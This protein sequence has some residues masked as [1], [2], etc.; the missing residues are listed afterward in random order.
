MR[1]NDNLEKYEA[2]SHLFI[3]DK[4]NKDWSESSNPVNINRMGYLA[5]II[6]EELIFFEGSQKITQEKYIKRAVLKPIED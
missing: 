2:K 1:N 4:Y 3:F 6:N 5:G